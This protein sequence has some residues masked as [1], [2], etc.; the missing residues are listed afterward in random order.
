MDKKDIK[1]LFAKPYIKYT[2]EDKKT[3]E[4]KVVLRMKFKPKDKMVLV[5][6]NVS[7]EMLVKQLEAKLK[8]EKPEWIIVRIP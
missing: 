2:I 8:K 1:I 3:K 6:M 7:N 4:N 5:D